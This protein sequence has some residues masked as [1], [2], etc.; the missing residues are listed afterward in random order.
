MKMQ[1]IEFLLIELQDDMDR[2]RKANFVLMIYLLCVCAAAVMFIYY[3][4]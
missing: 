3:G 2:M 4:N 1:E